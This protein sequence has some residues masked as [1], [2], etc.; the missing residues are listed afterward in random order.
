MVTPFARA[1]LS[2]PGHP[3]RPKVQRVQEVVVDAAVDDVDAALPLRRAHPDRVVPAGQVAALHEL[4]PHEPGQQGVLEVRAVVDAGGEHHH[5]RLRGAHRGS[6]LQ[7]GQQPLRVVADRAHPVR[8]EQ[9]RERPRHR[10]TV[11][12]HVAHAARRAQVVLQHPEGALLVPDEV[13]AAD[14]DAD[15]VGGHHAVRRAGV[16]AAAGHDATGDDAVPQHLLRA[17]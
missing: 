9:L 5:D 12:H 6:G 3:T 4:D 16:R 13:D 2:S 1:A 11:L 14:V 17:L 7:R 15:A 10:A 8:R